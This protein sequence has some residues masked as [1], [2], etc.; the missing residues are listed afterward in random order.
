M[1]E[2]IV[3]DADGNIKER[4]VIRNTIDPKAL[5]ETFIRLV[6][7][8][9][10]AVAGY[11]AIVALSVDVAADNPAV[12]GVTG[13]SITEDLDGDSAVTTTHENPADGTVTAPTDGSGQGTIVVTFTA[14][15][16]GV[17]V[18]QVVLTKAG[19]DD[20]SGGGPNPAI[21]DSDILAY[22]DVS[23]VTLSTD[24]TVQ[25]TWTIDVN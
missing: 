15:A 13:S 16:D 12:G 11:D 24:D 1:V 25:Y 10:G 21:A 3:R 6:Q 18:K 19:E 9:G 4:G 2:F 8:T 22:Q 7:G 14:R 5:D 20:T 23:D 17:Q